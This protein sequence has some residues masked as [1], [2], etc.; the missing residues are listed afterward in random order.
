MV[1]PTDAQ[2]LLFVYGTFR[3]GSENPHAA[4]LHRCCRYVTPATLPGKLYRIGGMAAVI[5]HPQANDK[6]VGDVLELSA[7]QRMPIL[8]TLDRYVGIG[9]GF[10]KPHAYKR[11][12]VTA[13]DPQGNLVECH[14]YLYEL[15]TSSVAIKSGD[16]LG[17]GL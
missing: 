14:A 5:H 4:F 1:T 7:A 12:M 9:N 15:R 6:V 17:D 2:S 8:E 11:R 13:Y 3:W 10:P 16:W